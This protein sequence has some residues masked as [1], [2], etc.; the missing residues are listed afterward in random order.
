MKQRESADQQQVIFCLRADSDVDHIVP[1]IDALARQRDYGIRVVIY[2]PIKTYADDY[3][4]QHLRKEHGIEAEHLLQLTAVGL[5]TKSLSRVFR[6]LF[7]GLLRLQ[8]RLPAPIVT[9]L[10]RL[11]LR[12]LHQ[13]LKALCASD[14]A[15]AALTEEVGRARNGLVV[16]D[17]T[18][19]P[20]AEAVTRVARGRGLATLALPHSVPH[21]TDLPRDAV[22]SPSDADG[23]DWGALY[24]RVVLPNAP[25][26]ERFAQDSRDD[27]LLT[28][29][30]SARFCRG[31]GP[32]L[33]RI[34]P[35]FDWNPGAGQAVKV[36]FILSKKGPYVDWP[37]INRVTERLCRDE[38]LS[39]VF[40]PHPRTEV[41]GLPSIEKNPRVAV[42]PPALPTVS[43]IR[44]ADLVVF[45]GSSV[46][47]DVIGMRK[48][49][50][51]LAYPFRLHF[52]FEPFL[53]SCRADSFEDFFARLDHFVET[54]EATY[55]E[56]DARDCMAALVEGESGPVLERYL[57][58][59]DSLLA[60]PPAERAF[61]ERP[62]SAQEQQSNDLTFG[63][64]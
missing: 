1:V 53:Q 26:A 32:T 39:V 16:F 47:Y 33:E 13:R 62:L 60:G 37:A 17:H 46:V 19:N 48:P 15:I 50:L 51:H 58:L 42:A 35:R 56:E 6:T 24:D 28:V 25:S 7:H 31:W 36:L 5:W 9:R 30:G 22:V 49:L 12:A 29:L 41:S 38:R 4:M 34:A 10:L 14:E 11:P 2:D 45:W 40:K 61:P 52:D 57:D 63:V 43:L 55:S 54:R 3:R 21:L 18:I 20:L 23:L 27:S 64:R 59:M 8:R 44:W